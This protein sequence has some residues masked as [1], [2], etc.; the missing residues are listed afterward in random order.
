MNVR[1]R[2]YRDRIGKKIPI[3]KIMP[4]HIYQQKNK[5][6]SWEYKEYPEFDI[7]F[8][9]IS[10][11]GT[12]GEIWKVGD[13]YIGLPNKDGKEI[14]NAKVKPR[15]AK[16]KRTPPPTDFDDLWDWYVEEFGKV[17]DRQRRDVRAE[18]VRRRESLIQ[19]YKKFVAS[20]FYKRKHGVFIKIDRTVMYI[21]GEHWM[22]LSHYYLTESDMYPLFRV[23]Q[24]EALWHWEA[25]R[26]D[27]RTWGEIRGKGR[28][29][30]WSV[31]SASMALNNFT[32]T[33]YA[34]IPIVSERDELA[35]EFFEDKIEPSFKYYP[36]YFKPLIPIPDFVSK[37]KLEIKHEAPKRPNSIIK[38]YPTKITAYDSK[39]VKYISINDEIGK[40]LN[41]SLVEFISRHSRTHLEGRGKA[42]F[43]STAGDYEKGGGKEFETEFKSANAQK[44]NAI[45]RTEN[46]LI[47]FFI[48]IVYTMTQ[49][50]SYFDE[51]GY[52]I[53]HDPKQ[54]ILNEHGKEVSIGAL[55]DW[56]T[57]FNQL[58]ATKDTTKLNAFLRDMP[59]T[60][61]HMFRNEGGV[62]ND[63]NM[64]NLNNQYDYLNN[65]DDYTLNSHLFRGDFTLER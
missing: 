12:L 11:D 16:W 50:V 13:L 24:M 32:I 46:G 58:K 38:Y 59:R 43:G 35:Q 23:T 53:V 61:E 63:F 54:P 40:W 44:R 60:P 36:I 5:E 4:M 1:D 41:T 20:E 9:C 47:S 52:S 18:F 8:I 25:V 19:K 49:P 29:T 34:R 62:N 15:D 51:W 42:R 33:K 37:G 26:A 31:E 65:I 55:T 2:S 14:I 56:E 22:F 7:N 39:K 21:T 48:D 28:R 30:S 10:K 3:R 6:K 45:G 57:T 27:S 17:T 64:Y